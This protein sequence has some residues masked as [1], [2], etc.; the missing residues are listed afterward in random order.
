[1]RVRE[2]EKKGRRER[3]SE[4]WRKKGRK[5]FRGKAT[6]TKKFHLSQSRE[7]LSKEEGEI[8]QLLLVSRH[9]TTVPY[10]KTGIQRR[11]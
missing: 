1:M 10:L 6:Q 11:W 4:Y 5:N 3:E 9:L 7:Q 8:D 2:E